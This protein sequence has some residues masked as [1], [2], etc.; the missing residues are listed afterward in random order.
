MNI[1]SLSLCY[2]S[3]SAPGAGRFVQQRLHALH[4]SHTVRVICPLLRSPRT[5]IRGSSLEAIRGSTPEAIPGSAVGPAFQPVKRQAGKPVPHALGPPPVWYVPMPYIPRLTQPINPH[6]YARAVYPL[7]SEWAA[8]GQ[9]DLIDA[10]F[11]WPDGVAAARLARR[12]GLPFTITLR[13]V[14]KRYANHLT[15]RRSIIGALREADA[16]I[17]VSQS[18]KAEAVKL[19]IHA[20]R[21]HVIPNGV[22]TAIFKPGD[23]NQARHALGRSPD[24]TLLITVSHLCRR[25]GIH[26]VL[27]M[28]PELI[29][30]GTGRKAR[31]TT[32]CKPCSAVSRATPPPSRDLRYVVIGAD[33]AEGRF[34]LHLTR[35]VKRLGLL[36]HVTFTGALPPAGV[37]QWLQAADLFVL[38]T[39]NEGCCNALCEALATGLPVVTTDVGGNAELVHP[40][41][42]RVVPYGDDRAFLQAIQSTLD[43]RTASAGRSSRTTRTWNLVAAE[44]AAALQ[45]TLPATGRPTTPLLG[46]SLETSRV[47]RADHPVVTH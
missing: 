3:P 40:C 21:I 44:T 8:S 28:L 1:V 16:L 30:R 15:K 43:D 31:Q 46:C 6:L 38:A 11:C 12:L 39:S 34:H 41:R 13:G 37:V 23:R 5:A 26:R 18:L 27:R 20:D 24:E 32:P 36:D 25:K 7:L 45:S 29:R 4:L 33:G 19:G 35:L 10:H 22:D 47:R 42:G 2:P 9:V 14:L 17:A